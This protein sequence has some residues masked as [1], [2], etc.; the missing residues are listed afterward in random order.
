M[1]SPISLF[2]FFKLIFKINW[3]YTEKKSCNYTESLLGTAVKIAARDAYFLHL[4]AF[5]VQILGTPLLS[6]L[7]QH[8]PQE[9]VGDGS[10]T[11]APELL[12][13]R[14]RL[15]YRLLISVGRNPVLGIWESIRRWKISVS[16]LQRKRK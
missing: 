6:V 9:A 8:T 14:P 11:W 16:A 2:F 4:S 12:S 7:H 15:S 13:G 3:N 1:T 10:S 5:L